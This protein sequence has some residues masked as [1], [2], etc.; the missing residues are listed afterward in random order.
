MPR[1]L[2][3]AAGSASGVIT[4]YG[5]VL[6]DNRV[7]GKLNDEDRSRNLAIAGK[8]RATFHIYK[9]EFVN[10]P[11]LWLHD[12]KGSAEGW[13]DARWVV[14]FD[15]TVDFCTAQIRANPGS[16]ANYNHRANVWKAKG[17]LDIAIA[18]LNEAIRLDPRGEVAYVNRGLAWSDK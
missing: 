12:E 1:P 11:W 4:Q 15:Q 13:I 17:E 7:G 16:S 8:D 10:G 9:V 18:D 6:N 14:P 2:P 5:A 3:R